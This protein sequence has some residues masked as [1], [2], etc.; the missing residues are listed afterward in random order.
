MPALRGRC[1][2]A[3]S[4][5]VPLRSRSPPTG[6]RSTLVIAELV[7]AARHGTEQHA[8]NAVEADHGRLKARLRP[9]R[10]LKTIGSLPRSQP[11][12]RSGRTC[13][14]AHYEHGTD[15]P[16]RT[17]CGSRSPTSSCP[18][19]PQRPQHSRRVPTCSGGDNA[20][21]PRYRPSPARTAATGPHE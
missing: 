16:S 10:G 18:S 21:A 11:G 1:S 19:N 8:N 12:T 17:A 2:P 5:L 6:H 4:T 20:L 3:R 9:M 13:V 14:A 15:R 7:P